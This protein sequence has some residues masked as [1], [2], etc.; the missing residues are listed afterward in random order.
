MRDRNNFTYDD[1][2]DDV[3][4]II[5]SFGDQRVTLVGESFGGTLVLAFALRHPEMIERLIVVN[6]FPRLRGCIRIRVAA[7]L[8]LLTPF[9]F[10]SLLRHAVNRLGL[11]VDGVSPKDRR[12]FL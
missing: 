8:G 7:C 2:T 11:L 1:L 3:A 5:Q 9:R 6:S 10:T 4:V 12:R